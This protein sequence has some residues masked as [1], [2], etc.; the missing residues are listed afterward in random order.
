MKTK[1]LSMLL[2]DLI[3]CGQKLTETAKALKGYYSSA[4]DV[5]SNDEKPGSEEVPA[6][7]TQDTKDEAPSYS[8]EDVRA[9]LATKAKVDGCKYK[10]EVKALVAKYSTDG[11]LTNIPEESYPLLVSE[12]EVLGNG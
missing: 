11:T 8:K 7:A 12:L 2:D 3:S 1:E 9:L 10:S 5:T 4:E 6:A